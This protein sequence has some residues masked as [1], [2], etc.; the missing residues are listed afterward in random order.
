MHKIV[1][2]LKKVGKRAIVKVVFSAPNKLSTMCSRVNKTA[3]TQQSCSIRHANQF[4]NCAEGAVY[5]VPLSCGKKYVGQTGRCLNE[6]LKEHHYNVL[7]LISGHLGLLCGDCGCS[8]IFSGT[9][10]IA[11]IGKKPLDNI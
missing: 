3:G 1:H 9:V 5:S 7:K 10:V 6:R 4:V 8:T 2:H 11:K